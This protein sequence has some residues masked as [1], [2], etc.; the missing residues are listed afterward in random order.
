MR[1]PSERTTKIVQCR[2]AGRQLGTPARYAGDAAGVAISNGDRRLAV[3]TLAW[4]D[5]CAFRP[6]YRAA[7]RNSANNAEITRR[8]IDRDLHEI[9]E[10][11]LS[12]LLQFCFSGAGLLQP[13][14]P[15]KTSATRDCRDSRADLCRDAGSVS[16]AFVLFLPADRAARARGATSRNAYR[17][18]PRRIGRAQANRQ[19]C[20]HAASRRLNEVIY[21]SVVSYLDSSAL[22]LEDR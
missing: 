14:L 19:R 8:I 12:N 9:S 7:D 11:R 5:R 17:G 16:A 3:T 21:R 2:R 6:E 22:H 20:R 15:G 13:E 10:L 1:P 4:I 18:R